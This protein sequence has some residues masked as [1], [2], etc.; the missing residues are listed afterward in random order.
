MYELACTAPR[1]SHFQSM[2]KKS[3][4]LCENERDGRESG[5]GRVR[6]AKEMVAWELALHSLKPS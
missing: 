4:V 1:K 2:L 3:L 5:V 6:T